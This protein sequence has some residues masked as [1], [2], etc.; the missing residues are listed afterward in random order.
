VLGGLELRSIMM[1]RSCASSTASIS[2][3]EAA[4]LP[5]DFEDTHT[6]VGACEAAVQL[7]E[8]CRRVGRRMSR[9][10]PGRSPS[11]G[12]T[13][14]NAARPREKAGL[15]PALHETK[16]LS[17]CGIFRTPPALA[18]ASPCPRLLLGSSLSPTRMPT[19][20]SEPVREHGDGV[21]LVRTGKGWRNAVR[22]D[23]SKSRFF[24]LTPLR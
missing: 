12:L 4:V 16:S 17:Q 11:I 15:G 22:R 23:V 24:E 8:L 6:V 5:Q 19:N 21:R 7:K 20:A 10:G 18:H 2:D 1:L 9:Q 14:L 3:S 13:H